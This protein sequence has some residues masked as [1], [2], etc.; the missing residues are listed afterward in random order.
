MLSNTGNILLIGSIVSTFNNL[1][2]LSKYKR[3]KF[4][5]KKNII[6]LSFFQITFVISSF[7]LLIFAFVFSDFSLIAVYQN[8]HSA[9]PLF[10]KISGVWGN[11]EGSMLLWIN[12]MV[13]FS[14]LFF[15]FNYRLNSSLSIY[16]LLIQNILILGFLI[17]LISDSNPFSKFYLYLEGLD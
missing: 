17:F 14:Y 16:T 4:P 12:I 1:F 5:N 13:I 10:Y 8:S 6:Y 2:C 3:K 9:K 15:V 11:H 7:L